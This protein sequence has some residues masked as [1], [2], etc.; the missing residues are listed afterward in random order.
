MKKGKKEG[1]SIPGKRDIET[2]HRERKGMWV[3][4]KDG[5]RL[6]YAQHVLTCP[7]CP[8]ADGLSW[9]RSFCA[10]TASPHG[11]N[12]YTLP[13]AAAGV[14]ER[15]G[16]AEVRKEFRRHLAHKHAAR[17][18]EAKEIVESR[19]KRLEDME[20]VITEGGLYATQP[21]QALW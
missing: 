14:S 20:D 12:W 5:R 2:S 3:T 4:L 7:V 18:A 8:A 19:S 10:V 9:W 11:C 17:V 15:H 6:F 16:R 1:I 21:E 13:F